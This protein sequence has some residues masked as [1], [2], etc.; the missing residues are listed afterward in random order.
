M[1]LNVLPT[2]F[3]TIHLRGRTLLASDHDAEMERA[4][5]DELERIAAYYFE[6][7][8][9]WSSAL[10]SPP[11]SVDIFLLFSVDWQ[12]KPLKFGIEAHHTVYDGT[13]VLGRFMNHSLC[14][15]NI[16]PKFYKEI[17]GNKLE[18]YVYFESTKNIKVC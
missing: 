7:K 9:K 4:S 2:C 11:N 10:H 6:H 17:H 13:V 14:C 12:G 15:T 1:L 18:I 16:I 5:A 8:C 3:T